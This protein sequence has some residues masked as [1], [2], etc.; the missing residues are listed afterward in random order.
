MD[1]F[2]WGSGLLQDCY[3]DKRV[4]WHKINAFYVAWNEQYERR[5]YL[6]IFYY[7]IFIIN[8]LDVFPVLFK[9]RREKKNKIM[10]ECFCQRIF[11]FMVT[12]LSVLFLLL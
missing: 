6:D 7:V 3:N 8:I 10:D 11:L 1:I 5:R 9:R 4:K 2:T 12:L